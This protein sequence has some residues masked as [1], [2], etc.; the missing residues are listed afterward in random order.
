M[1]A[2]DHRFVSVLFNVYCSM[3][4][5]LNDLKLPSITCLIF[6]TFQSLCMIV[7]HIASMHEAS[8]LIQ[9]V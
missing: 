1:G 3:V 4:E 7:Q 5:F 2:N 6:V 9:L 8:P